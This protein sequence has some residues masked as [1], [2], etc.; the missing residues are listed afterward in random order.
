MPP[1]LRSGR[2]SLTAILDEVGLGKTDRSSQNSVFCFTCERSR[3]V[4]YEACEAPQDVQEEGSLLLTISAS[5]EAEVLMEIM[6]HGS[7]LEVLE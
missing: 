2:L 6:K 1:C 4:K 7:Y 3:G 5:H